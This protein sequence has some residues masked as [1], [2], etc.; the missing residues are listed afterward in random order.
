[1]ITQM[2]TSS[3]T[4]ASC[5]DQVLGFSGESSV[6]WKLIQGTVRRAQK[7]VIDMWLI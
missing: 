5:K 4:M 6:M 1:M 3:F 2:Q 7:A